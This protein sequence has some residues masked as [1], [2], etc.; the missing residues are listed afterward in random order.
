[1]NDDALEVHTL[2][3]AAGESS[4]FG[5]PKQLLN[6][7][8]E[9]LLHRAC[10]EAQSVCPRVT[11]VLG[12]HADCMIDAIADLPLMRITNPDWRSGMASSIC[13]G[14]LSL[15]AT[16]DGVMIVLC[17]QPAVTGQHLQTLIDAW[18]GQPEHIITSRYSGINGVPA[19]FPRDQFAGLLSLAGDQGARGLIESRV[20]IVTPIDLPVAAHDIDTPADMED[21]Q[22]RMNMQIEPPVVE[23]ATDA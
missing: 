17:D 23:T 19:I 4:R 15:P 1:M 20:G 2:I 21:L 5:S 11:V 22:T 7:N 13:A 8:N 16:A 6:V 12:A 10:R 14:V 18:H 3:L 9:T